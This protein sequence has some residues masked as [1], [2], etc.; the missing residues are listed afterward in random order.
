M[1]VEAFETL[2]ARTRHTRL[3]ADYQAALAIYAGDLLP[4]D[5]YEDWAIARRAGLKSLALEVFL[6]LATVLV[7]RNDAE[8][9]TDVLLRA[10]ELDAA[11]EAAHSELMRIYSHV[12]QRHHALRQYEHMRKALQS[13]IDVEPSEASQAL[14]DQV[15]TGRPLPDR[16]WLCAA[17]NFC[18]RGTPQL[19]GNGYQFHRARARGARDSPRT[20]SD[21]VTHAHRY[22]RVRKD[23]TRAR[24]S[25]TPARPV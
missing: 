6:E 2:A 15:R 17:W 10:L 23:E 24:S 22:R 11:C 16:S 20:Q 25:G 9:A 19:A 18:F 3:P 8:S 7:Q 13:E 14:Y 5:S 12:G 4:D 1:D 21:A